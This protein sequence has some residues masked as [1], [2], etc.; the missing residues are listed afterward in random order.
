MEIRNIYKDIQHM[1][2]KCDVLSKFN[3]KNK[4][5]KSFFYNTF[6]HKAARCPLKAHLVKSF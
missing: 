5:E 1:N 4:K 3:N 2:S 6:Q